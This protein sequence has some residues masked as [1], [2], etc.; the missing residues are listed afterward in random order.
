MLDFKGVKIPPRKNQ[1]TGLV[2]RP[3]QID[4]QEED[5][6]DEEQGSYEYNEQEN[7]SQSQVFKNVHEAEEVERGDELD[8]YTSSK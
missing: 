4:T 5:S 8:Q 3:P 2:G 1:R 7:P 6:G